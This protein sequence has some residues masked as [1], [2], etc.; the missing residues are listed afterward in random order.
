MLQNLT[1]SCQHR[2]GSDPVL[3]RDRSHYYDALS[4]PVQIS[5]Q[6][7][8]LV[9]HGII[10]WQQHPPITRIP[11]SCL[12]YKDHY[13]NAPSQWETTL[14]C[15]V[16]SHWLGA[17]T[18]WSPV[19]FEHA[20]WYVARTKHEACWMRFADIPTPCKH[21]PRSTLR[22]F[23]RFEMWFFSGMNTHVL[24]LNKMNQQLYFGNNHQ[25][26]R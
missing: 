5:L 10:F 17:C 2:H 8:F 4:R 12:S 7:I 24:F 1:K 20:S 14:Q 15:N 13:V 16:V 19:T 18:K 25:R 22:S 21:F 26:Q 11:A 9:L 23:S 3:V 6:A